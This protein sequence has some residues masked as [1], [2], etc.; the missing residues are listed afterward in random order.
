MTAWRD[1]PVLVTGATG[2]LGGWLVEALLDRSAHVVGLVRDSVPRSRLVA[3]RVIDRIDVVWG[4]VAD[5]AGVERA[6]SLIVNPHKWLFTPFD[7]S[8]L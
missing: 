5:F 7:L 3:E 8:V 1:R 2:L 4:D 6:D